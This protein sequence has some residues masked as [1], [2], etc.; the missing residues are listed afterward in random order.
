MMANRFE[1]IE[2]ARNEIVY[3]Q[4]EDVYHFFVIIDD[5]RKIN[6][7]FSLYPKKI[8]TCKWRS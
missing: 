1:V 7:H 4:G 8:I 5:K 3:K 2:I 6:D